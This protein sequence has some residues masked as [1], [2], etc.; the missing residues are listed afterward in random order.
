MLICIYSDLIQPKL[1]KILHTPIYESKLVDLI[2]GEKMNKAKVLNGLI[3]LSVFSLLISGCSTHISTQIPVKKEVGQLNLQSKKFEQQVKTDKVIAIVS[4]VFAARNESAKV[5]NTSATSGMSPYEAMLM[6][7]QGTVK[8]STDFKQDF[9]NN[10]AQRL[11]KAFESSISEMLAAKGFKLQGPFSNFDDITY[12]E[13]KKIYLAFVPKVDFQIEKKVLKSKKE[14][15]YIHEEGVIQ[16]GG[17]LIVTMVEPMT[18]ETFIKKRINLSDFNIEEPYLQDK[19][20]RVEGGLNVATAMDKISAPDFIKDTT[21][22]ALT[23]AINE[24]YTK[25]INKIDLYLDREEILSYEKDI[26]KLKGLKRF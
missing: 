7:R 1:H 22:V 10:Y 6:G 23:K 14:R 19:Q 16:I 9:A 3:A 13:K 17:N 12:R 5:Q 21:D 2:F 26:L 25:A 4:P 8:G 15:L 20:Y 24:F 18:G 11:S